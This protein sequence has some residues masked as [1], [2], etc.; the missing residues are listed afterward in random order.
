MSQQP[1]E[2]PPENI[3]WHQSGVSPNGEPFIQLIQNEKII[4]QMSVEQGRDHAKAIL[5][6]CEAAEQD[7]FIMDFAQ[8]EIGLDFNRA[9][10][11]LMSFRNYRANR[12]GK[13][14]GPTSPR[15]WVMP[16]QI[17]EYPGLDLDHLKKKKTP[18]N[19]GK[20]E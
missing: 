19:P 4:A 10:H 15:D 6:A 14:Q 3:L 5:E 18:E 20:K 11:L 9:G 7:A 16:D 12:T 8:S 1:P 13:S 17:P 2:P